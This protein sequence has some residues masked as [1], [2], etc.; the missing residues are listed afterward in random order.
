MFIPRKALKQIENLEREGKAVVIYGPRRVG[1]TTLL[2][3]Y[4]EDK[5]N[6]LFVTGE[7]IFVQEFLSSHSVEKLKKFSIL[8]RVRSSDQRYEIAPTLKLLFSVE[9]IQE[10]TAVYRRMFVGDEQSTEPS[11]EA[12]GEQ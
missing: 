3:K 9:E 8:Q 2:K 4:L 6:Y 12:E 10:L 1:K 7:D 11:P 5:Q